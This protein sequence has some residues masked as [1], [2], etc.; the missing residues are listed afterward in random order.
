MILVYIIAPTDY[1]C[2]LRHLKMFLL[3]S[4]LMKSHNKTF[5]TGKTE[6]SVLGSL[7]THESFCSER[8]GK[9]LKGRVTKYVGPQVNDAL[10]KFVFLLNCTG[11]ILY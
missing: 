4:F 6:H 8:F 7:Q 9:L 1:C 5:R 10:V 2:T 11:N 3:I